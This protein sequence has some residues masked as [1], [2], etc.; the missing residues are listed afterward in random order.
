MELSRE[1]AA[2]ELERLAREIA[3]HDEHYHSRD[4]AEV[5]DAEYDAL[6]RRNDAI[7]ARFPDLVRD[8]SPS[9]R[10]GAAP[11]A[12]FAKVAHA[13]PMLSL[14][15]AFDAGDVIDFYAR[16]RRFLGLDV[17]EPVEVVAEPKIDGLSISLRY[18]DGRFVLGATRGDGAVG[19]NVT[20]NLMT[21]EDAPDRLSGNVPPVLEVR[22]EVYMR[23][24][25]FF[26]LNRGR[27]EAGEAPFANPRNAAAGSLRQL[28]AEVT[29][30]RP[31]RLF[32]Y[33][34]GEYSGEVGET[35]WSYLGNLEAWG[36]QV[37]PMA[38]LCRTPEEAIALYDR[39]SS[40]RADLDH[41]IDGVVYK[42]N[43][44]D[45]QRRLGN[46]SRAPRWAVAHKFPAERAETV[47]EAI[48]IQVGRTGALTPVANLRPVTVGGV[49][50]S[51]ATL[52]N[53]DEIARKGVREGDTVVIQRAGDVIP[54]VVAVVEAKR[55][56]SAQTF[57]F[58][59][60]CPECG[61]LALREEGEAV[62]LC[63]GGLVCPAQAVE[64]LKHFVS[65]DAFD[66]EGLGT[67]HIET[68]WR[69]KLIARPGDIFRLGDH[70]TAL[71]DREGWAE[72]S[73]A[74]LLAAIEER[75]AIPF[76]RLVYA[77]GIPQV[78]QATARLIA[79]QYQTLPAWRD[80]MVAARDREGEAY[81]E[82]TD[83]DGIG[84][85]VA[86]DIVDFFR[87]AHNRN[88][89][90]DLEIQLE[91]SAPEAVATASVVSGKT[92]VFTGT[93]ETM[94]R[95]EAKARAESLGVKVV[96]SVSRKT[97]YVVVGSDAGSKA[98]KAEELGVATLSEQDWRELIG[99]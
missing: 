13:A 12:G 55:P 46:V 28:D 44:F 67:K 73:V 7:E 58:P 78:G 94:T 39:I 38:K 61:S 63:T 97:D 82:L 54:Q 33:G 79:R 21:M 1:E 69:E 2:S 51:R 53:E 66:M 34:L 15:N 91:I 95:A 96:G 84:P 35:H 10:V 24:Q 29:A 90:E 50:V 5:S 68:F 72:R 8:D 57:V 71:V 42:V 36:F 47:L 76:E 75:R 92:V 22:G 49:V 17:D 18:Q 30:G 3:Y 62:R 41:D 32:A 4:A 16:V 87:E 88:V 59:D 85:S 99:G 48:T 80:A 83:I 43:R 27:E 26:A 37:N 45:W 52:H 23:H 19:E 56:A 64:R 9:H 81:R 86:A 89:V 40:G 11:S 60:R 65:R 77:L 31:L 70:R 25:D 14:G 6:R 20:R 93:L 74:N 98:R